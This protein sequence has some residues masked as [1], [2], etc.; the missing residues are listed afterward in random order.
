VCGR[1][2]ESQGT[3]MYMKGNRRSILACIVLVFV[4]VWILGSKC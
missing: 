3:G 1:E 4:E 2:L